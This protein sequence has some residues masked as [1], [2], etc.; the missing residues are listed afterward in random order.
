MHLDCLSTTAK[1]QAF[2]SLKHSALR[3][4]N[5]YHIVNIADAWEAGRFLVHHILTLNIIHAC[6]LHNMCWI[7]TNWILSI[8]ID[9]TDGIKT[10]TAV[11]TLYAKQNFIQKFLHVLLLNAGTYWGF[12][13]STKYVIT[14][15]I[16]KTIIYQGARDS[17]IVIFREALT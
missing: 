9:L 3:K 4:L 8:L 12:E 17:Q 14:I 2:S 13:I 7:L 1:E 15:I 11:G 6:M 5:I 16:I 10:K